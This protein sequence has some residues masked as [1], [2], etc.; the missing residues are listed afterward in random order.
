MLYYTHQILLFNYIRIIMGKIFILKLDPMANI[1]KYVQKG[2]I[3]VSIWSLR[4]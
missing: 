1:L 4:V 2:Y 3:S